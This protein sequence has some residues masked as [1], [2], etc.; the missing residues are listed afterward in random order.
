LIDQDTGLI[1][2][3]CMTYLPK[4][5]SLSMEIVA[6]WTPLRQGKEGSR[7]GVPN[8]PCTEVGLSV[9]AHQTVRSA[10]VGERRAART[11]G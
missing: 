9:S 8:E 3:R 1:E 5:S 2:L 4:W 11:A 7:S 6:F 10:S